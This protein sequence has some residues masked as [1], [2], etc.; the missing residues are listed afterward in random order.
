MWGFHGCHQINISDIDKLTY[1]L[2]QLVAQGN[3]T[4]SKEALIAFLGGFSGA[5][6]AFIFERLATRQDKRRERYKKH[7][8]AL[9]KIEY[10]VVKQQDGVNRL[11]YL[12]KSSAEKMSQEQPALPANRFPKLKIFDDIELDLGDIN[13]INEVS[14]YWLSVDRVNNDTETINR[15]LDSINTALLSDIKVDRRNFVHVADNMNSLADHLKDNVLDEN[16]SLDAYVVLL[17]EKENA[18]N[19]IVKALQGYKIIE[20]TI[21]KVAREK[22]KLEIY[23]EIKNRIEQDRERIS[24]NR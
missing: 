4:F 20:Y 17:M 14:D 11:I 19:K 18:R 6:F 10:I 2:E 13:L 22:K 8:D 9:V 15:L 16:V 7:R 3:K 12:L 21:D 5:F 1:N 24:R 23:K